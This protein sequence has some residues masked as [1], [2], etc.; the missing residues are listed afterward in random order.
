MNE[1]NIDE[2]EFAKKRHPAPA[3]TSSNNQEPSNNQNFTLAEKHRKHSWNS[4]KTSF[5]T[6]N[7]SLFAKHASPTPCTNHA[8]SVCEQL[9]SIP[10]I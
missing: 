9:R 5:T 2:R 1:R 10:S 8:P 6:Q 4:G 3:T 7:M